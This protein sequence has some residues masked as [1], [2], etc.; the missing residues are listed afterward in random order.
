MNIDKAVFTFA[1]ATVLIG[2]VLAQFFSPYWLLLP[3]CVG[4]NLFQA[5]I[6]GFCPMAK[7]L[8]A[9]GLRPR[10]AFK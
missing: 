10:N 7:F 5:G 2:L 8:K 6:T 3:A 9:A 4:L 1:G